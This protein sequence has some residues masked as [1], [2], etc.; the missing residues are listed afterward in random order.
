MVLP[1]FVELDNYPRKNRER[2]RE[3]VLI[4]FLQFSYFKKKSLDL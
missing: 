3:R 2:E 4:I 1:E